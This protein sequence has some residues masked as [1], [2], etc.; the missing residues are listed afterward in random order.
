MNIPTVQ[1]QTHRHQERTCCQGGGER[2]GRTWNLGQQMQTITF[3]MD[4]QWGLLYSTG[5]YI[6][7]L[8]IEH[9]GRQYEKKNVCIC[10][11]VSPCYT[12]EIGTVLSINYTLIFNLKKGGGSLQIF[13]FLRISLIFWQLVAHSNDNKISDFTRSRHLRTPYNI[14]SRYGLQ[15]PASLNQ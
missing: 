13:S 1:K 14:K 6:Q 15:C 11:T 3:K 12:A 10:T 9:Y 5:N 7:S 8:V 2:V 4:K